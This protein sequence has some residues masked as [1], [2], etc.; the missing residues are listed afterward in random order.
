MAVHLSPPLTSPACP[1]S[2][3]SMF[4]ATQWMPISCK[5]ARWKNIC[6]SFTYLFMFDVSAVNIM[7]SAFLFTTNPLKLNL[8]VLLLLHGNPPFIHPLI[9]FEWP[10][11]TRPRPSTSQSRL[12]PSSDTAST[13]AVVATTR[14]L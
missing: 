12:E 14:I 7:K 13:T 10:S 1:R 11:L 4:A 6:V 5:M 3:L 8:L 2:E 9:K